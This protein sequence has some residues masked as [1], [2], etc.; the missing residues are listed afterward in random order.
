MTNHKPKQK[1]KR[2]PSVYLQCGYEEE[3][4]TRDCL[5]NC[6]RKEKMTLMITEADK[7]IIEDFAMI[8]LEQMIADDKKKEL[9]L[10]QNI[11]GKLMMK[12][13]NEEK[14]EKRKI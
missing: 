2:R 14:N 8:D 9:E 11:M 7:C 12:V 1:P 13:F 4:E 3:C 10:M 6:P 5:N